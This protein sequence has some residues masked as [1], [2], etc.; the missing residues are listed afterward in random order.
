MTNGS[1]HHRDLG[2]DSKR[3]ASHWDWEYSLSMD[4]K[5]TDYIF[6]AVDTVRRKRVNLFERNGTCTGRLQRRR[7]LEWDESPTGQNGNRTHTLTDT[8]RMS[9]KNH[10][11]C[12]GK[13]KRRQEGIY[14][15]SIYGARATSSGFGGFD[16]EST[17]KIG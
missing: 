7:N 3:R 4:S 1:Q 14:T 6:V 16:S 17:G 8:R 12:I 2:R 13:N 10:A 15:S 11:H 5:Q 9:A